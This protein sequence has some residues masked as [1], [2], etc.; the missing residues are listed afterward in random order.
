MARDSESLVPDVERDIELFAPNVE[1]LAPDVARIY[2][3]SDSD[4]NGETTVTARSHHAHIQLLKGTDIEFLASDAPDVDVTGYFRFGK[5]RVIGP[6][7]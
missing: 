7:S 5:E 2:G 4:W 1:L 6:G 3:C